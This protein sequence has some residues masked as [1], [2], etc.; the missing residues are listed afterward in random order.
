MSEE[1]GPTFLGYLAAIGGL[2]AIGAFA[3]GLFIL[4]I[5]YPLP[6]LML[7]SAC[8]GCGALFSGVRFVSRLLDPRE[9]KR[10]HS[11]P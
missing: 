2:L 5:L 9:E 7:A 10:P 1:K 11:A 3:L 4:A 6:A 8:C